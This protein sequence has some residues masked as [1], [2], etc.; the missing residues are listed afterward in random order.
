M[1]ARDRESVVGINASAAM[2][3][4]AASDEG[5]A[6]RC[7]AEVATAGEGKWVVTA[8][9]GGAMGLGAAKKGVVVVMLSSA[10]LERGAQI[11]DGVEEGVI[12]LVVE[13]TLVA[14]NWAY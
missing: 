9:V 6:K 12:L 2:V 10:S 14:G 7:A 11:K 5:G 13:K 1:E 4:G 3:A 8:K